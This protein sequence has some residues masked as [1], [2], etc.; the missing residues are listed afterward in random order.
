ME[1]QLVQKFI[2]A[3]CLLAMLLAVVRQVSAGVGC[4]ESQRACDECCSPNF[5][6][7]T[8]TWCTCV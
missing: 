6:D 2:V 4:S 1:N 8:G 3:L 5:G 7:L